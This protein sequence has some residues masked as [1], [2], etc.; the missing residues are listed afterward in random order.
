VGANLKPLARVLELLGPFW[1]VVYSDSIPDRGGNNER[2]AYV[3]DKRAVAF[4]G[5]AAEADLPRRK[6]KDGEWVSKYSWWRSP[7]LASFRAGNFDFVVLCAHIRWGNSDP[8]RIRALKLLAQWVHDRRK[9]PNCVDQDIIVLGDFNVPK[10]GDKFHKAL[11]SKGLTLASALAA[12]KL[13]SNLEMTAKYDQILH[14]PTH[15]KRFT[16]NAGVLDFHT[17]GINKLFPGKKLT[18]KRYT[19]Q[20]SDHLPLWVEIDT[21]I[22]DARLDQIIKSK[23]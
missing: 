21:Y 1:R 22:D 17:G 11:T 7:Y 14:Y 6:N 3:Y 20:M 5:L 19:Y 12:V 4:T 9:S 2:I 23:D 16:Q 15:A 10:I 13:G 8:G 18:E